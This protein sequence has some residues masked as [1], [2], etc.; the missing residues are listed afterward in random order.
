VID[1][2]QRVG[3]SPGIHEVNGTTQIGRIGRSENF[4]ARTKI[5]SRDARKI[6]SRS[7]S[8]DDM[9][10]FNRYSDDYNHLH[11]LGYHPV[12]SASGFN[13]NYS[14]INL[15]KSD[16]FDNTAFDIY[17]EDNSYVS[18]KIN[19]DKYFWEDTTTELPRRFQTHRPYSSVKQDRKVRNPEEPTFDF[20]V[21]SNTVKSRSKSD[22]NI[23]IPHETARVAYEDVD[24]VYGCQQKEIFQNKN[25]HSNTL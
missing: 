19:N 5:S 16:R 24:Q 23:F 8:P 12:T 6:R 21:F 7:L 14:K 11:C 22:D 9:E 20:C 1:D 10:R 2:V 4:H 15:T 18:L 17:P 3:G 13:G 25:L